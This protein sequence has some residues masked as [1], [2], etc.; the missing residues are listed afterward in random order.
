MS[1]NGTW[2][3]AHFKP[4]IG[5][6]GGLYFGETQSQ[7]TK[8][9]PN[10]SIRAEWWHWNLIRLCFPLCCA[11]LYKLFICLLNSSF[12]SRW[13]LICWHP[14]R[15]CLQRVLWSS[16]AITTDHAQLLHCMQICLSGT[17]SVNYL[18]VL[19]IEQMLTCWIM[20]TVEIEKYCCCQTQRSS[21]PVLI[22]WK[23]IIFGFYRS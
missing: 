5:I 10:L 20:K 3:E 8:A 6:D 23:H 16:W 11:T 19:L 12:S 14:Q 1:G 9:W 4:T 13:H 18:H 15:S 17:L 7:T 22:W 21:Y 2:P